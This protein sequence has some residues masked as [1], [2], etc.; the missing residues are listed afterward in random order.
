MNLGLSIFVCTVTN[1]IHFFSSDQCSQLCII[2][3]RCINAM[4]HYNPWWYFKDTVVWDELCVTGSS[5]NY[6]S[7]GDMLCIWFWAREN[8]V[9]DMK[10]FSQSRWILRLWLTS[11]FVFDSE[12]VLTLRTV[13]DHTKEYETSRLSF[14]SVQLKCFKGIR[15][16]QSIHQ[17]SF[18]LIMCSSVWQTGD[19][20]L[21]VRDQCV[22]RL[23]FIKAQKIAPDRDHWVPLFLSITLSHLTDW[24]S[25]PTAEIKYKRKK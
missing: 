9:A 24:T 21:R 17:W 20:R 2:Y 13:F 11:S 14:M 6:W 7:G 15:L 16:S 25:V 22:H 4:N 19:D 8:T 5:R 10:S 18:S 23:D 12:R 1:E 3:S